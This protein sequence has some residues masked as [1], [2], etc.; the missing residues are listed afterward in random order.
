MDA[1]STSFRL[2]VPN[3]VHE[4][5]PL[6]YS[7]GPEAFDYI[8]EVKS[9]GSAQ[10]FIHYA[11]RSEGGEM[12]FGKHTCAIVNDRVVGI[13]A[14]FGAK[15]NIPHTL[16][17]AW[18]ILRFYGVLQGL[19]VMIRGLRFERMISPPSKGEFAIVHIGVD[20]S[21]QRRG[22]GYKLMNHLI[23]IARTSGYHSAILDVA[24]RN[25]N[26]RLLY[27]RLGFKIKHHSPSSLKGKDQSKT[28]PG[29]YLMKLIL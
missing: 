24:E 4:A 25:D 9:K 2:A 7:S 6:I 8:F 26:A 21:M 10:D 20:P 15:S 17:I 19:G 22:I 16:N 1:V 29:H 14:G 27:E 11:F 13:G 5:V 28:V 3:D 12:G 18:K 23:E